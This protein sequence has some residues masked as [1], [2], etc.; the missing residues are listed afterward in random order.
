M[1]NFHYSP[2]LIMLALL[3]ACGPR[4]AAVD[5]MPGRTALVP[6][7]SGSSL[8]LA[9]TEPPTLS[10][11]TES[12]AA[13]LY[14]SLCVQD[15]S[16]NED[17]IGISVTLKSDIEHVGPSLP[18]A[19]PVPEQGID[20]RVYLLDPSHVKHEYEVSNGPFPGEVPADQDS[21]SQVFSFE[22]NHPP[23]GP[24]TLHIPT[25]VLVADVGADI[26]LDLGTHP[27]QESTIPMA[28]SFRLMGQKIRFT[29]AEVDSQSNLHVFSDPIG[30]G[31]GVTLRWLNAGMP[32]GWTS[33]TGPGNKYNF[34]AHVQDLWFPVV[35]AD[36]TENTGPAS[37]HIYDAV[38]YISGPFE[39]DFR[40]N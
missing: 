38:I 27:M 11:P 16:I 8:A 14:V 30:V 1:A 15:V 35:N 21:A 36:G 32:Q 39:I 40:V 24:Y 22:V 19:P 12:C 2:L 37:F 34:E 6:N 23:D 13:N 20:T 4:A 7:A 26:S 10:A 5:Q 18:F 9:T 33:G 3:S 17:G 29:H 31:H 28:G 25:V